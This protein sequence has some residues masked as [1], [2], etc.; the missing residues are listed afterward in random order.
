MLLVLSLLP[1]WGAITVR[2]TNLGELGRLPGATGHFNAFYGYGWF[3]RAAVVVAVVVGTIAFARR[4]KPLGIPRLL[5]LLAGMAVTAGVF[6][7]L[8]RGPD[9]T[10]FDDVPRVEVRRG[11]LI[12]AAVI[13]SL[14]MSAAGLSF[15]HTQRPRKR[16]SRRR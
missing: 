12:V 3:L 8:V 5:Y 9:V 14:T 6:I 4:F 1:G 16:R 7:A 2:P 10:G 11:P 15:A 13:P